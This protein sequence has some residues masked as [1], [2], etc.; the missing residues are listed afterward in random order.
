RTSL[1]IDVNLALERIRINPTKYSGIVYV[2]TYGYTG[3]NAE[4]FFHEVKNLNT[5]ILI[6]DDHCL[7]VPKFEPWETN[8]NV[9][10]FSTGYSKVGELGWG[11]YAYI[12]SEIDYIRNII[13]YNSSAH[14]ELLN[15][16]NESIKES[17]KIYYKESDWLDGTAPSISF[18]DYKNQVNAKLK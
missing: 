18:E 3:F 7:S 5:D 11:G 10:L 1:S 12:D 6:I 4:I 13:D 17:K 9:L 8:A 15:V 16:F 14:D 2:R